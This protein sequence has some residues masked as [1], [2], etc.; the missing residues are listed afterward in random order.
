MTY[1]NTDKLTS[2][3]H[4]SADMS[5]TA[6]SPWPPGILAKKKTSEHEVNI[7]IA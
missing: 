4:K 6:T 3:A 1:I 5:Q 2:L 7:T